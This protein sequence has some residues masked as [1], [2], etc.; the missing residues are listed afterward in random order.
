[1]MVIA[2]LALSA[3]LALREPASR[4]C[5]ACWPE[6]TRPTCT[7]KELLVTIISSLLFA[8]DSTCF[9]RA[10]GTRTSCVDI[11]RRRFTFT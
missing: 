6:M 2:A 11:K 3:Q 9:D 1:M 5:L 10:H 7:G 4:L 8:L